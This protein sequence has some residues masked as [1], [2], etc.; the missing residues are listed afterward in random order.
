MLMV[1]KIYGMI[2]DPLMQFALLHNLNLHLQAYRE[3][4]TFL[5]PTNGNH[6]KKAE[7]WK[8]FSWSLNPK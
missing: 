7:N 1:H 4:L 2:L 3:Y 6:L 5:I 8:I